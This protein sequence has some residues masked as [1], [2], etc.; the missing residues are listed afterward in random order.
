MSPQQGD[1]ATAPGPGTRLA[2]VDVA[3]G[4]AIVAMVI[5]H[6]AFD[7]SLQRMFGVNIITDPAWTV[8]ARLIAGT[9]LALVGFSL[10][11]A[12]ARG[13]RLRRFLVRLGILA[14]LAAIVSG[15]TFAFDSGTFVYFGI[16]HQIALSS[17]AGALFLRAPL[18]ILLA[19]AAGAFALPHV[20]VSPAFNA[21]WLWWLGLSTWLPPSIDYVPFLPWFGVTLLGLVAGRLFLARGTDTAL[22]RWEPA[23]PVFGWLATAGRWALT[24][25]MLHQ[26]ILF[27]LIYLI[28]LAVPA[29]LR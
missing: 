3:R 7:L 4:V 9:F 5:Y 24:I 29:G 18:P 19:V 11:L 12:H 28:G 2:F 17:L 1:A 6:A 20:A 26:P 22:A 10:A 14:A 23:N 27:G 8:F 21:P 16:L 15:A 25:Y 13:F